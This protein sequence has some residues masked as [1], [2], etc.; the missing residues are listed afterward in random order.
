[1]R[2]R[3]L[4]LLVALVFLCGCEFLFEEAEVERMAREAIERRDPRLCANLTDISDAEDCFTKVAV[5]LNQSEACEYIKN[6]TAAD[7]CNDGVAI[8]SKDFSPCKKIK[9]VK[10]KLFCYG[11]VGGVKS[12]DKLNQVYGWGS[13]LYRRLFKK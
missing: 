5:G 6:V 4:V 1:M 9:S 8:E 13:R 12:V 3:L 2:F 7:L 11:K 10:Q